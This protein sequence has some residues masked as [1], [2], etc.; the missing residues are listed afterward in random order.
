MVVRRKKQ[1]RVSVKRIRRFLRKVPSVRNAFTC[2][3]QEATNHRHAAYKEYKA[4][5]KT[6]AQKMRENFQ[7]TLAEAIALKKGTDVE[8]EANNLRRI[9]KQRRQARNVKRMRGKIG[10]SRVTKI[11]YTDDDGTRVQCDTQETMES[12]CLTEND[13]R[14]S[15]TETSPPMTSQH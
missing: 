15:Q 1:V 6:E 7:G 10:N 5:R 12:A 11:W 9:E 8:T 4:A 13:G 14:F 2:S 3:L